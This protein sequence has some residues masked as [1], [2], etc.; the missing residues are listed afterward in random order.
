MRADIRRAL[1]LLGLSDERI[2][3]FAR[4]VDN[5][6]RQVAEGGLITRKAQPAGAVT[7][8]R[9]QRGQA[10][11][12]GE[13][14]SQGTAPR[15]QRGQGSAQIAS[16]T[17]SKLKPPT[18]RITYRGPQPRSGQPTPQARL[19]ERLSGQASG[20][21]VADEIAK[22]E[23]Q[24][25]GAPCWKADEIRERI[26]TLKIVGNTP[27]GAAKGT[28]AHIEASQKRWQRSPRRSAT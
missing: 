10:G 25:E 12:P 5:V 21:L 13:N 7:A 6:K 28:I 9:A 11:D 17:L 19:V 14:F 15:A 23:A 3:E 2:D 22:L 4:I 16:Q 26:K 8:P 24:I 1:S 20:P 18:V 27:E